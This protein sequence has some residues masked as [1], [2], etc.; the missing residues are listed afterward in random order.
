[1]E[2]EEQVVTRLVQQTITVT[3]AAPEIDAPEEPINLD[4][5]FVREGPP[6][7]DPQRTNDEDGID[8]IENIFVGLTRYNHAS[9]QIEPE[10]AKE[11]EVSNNGRTWTFHLR[12]DIFWIQP[13]ESVTNGKRAVKAVRQVVAGDLVF[14][15]QRA[16]RRDTRMPDAFILF[17]IEG[18]EQ[19]NQ[20]AT[21]TPA[22]L[23]NIGIQALNDQTLQIS[24]TKPASHFLT[25]TSMWFFRPMPP[26]LF[27]E[28]VEDWMAPELFMTSGPFFPLG[29]GLQKLQRNP[30]W[31]IERED[32]NVDIVNIYYLDNDDNALSLWEAKTLDVID[33]GTLD[34]SGFNS[35]T[36]S[37]LTVIPE[38]AL[39]YLAFNFN[40]GVFREPEVRR[41]FSA[42]I[43][44]EALVEEIYGINA[45]A[46]R[47]LIPPGVIAAPPID[48][49]GVGYSPDYARQ[50]MA[51]SGFSSCRLMP[52]ITFTVSSSDLS[53]LQAELIV[54]MWV[55]ELGC[56]EEQFI[57]EQVQFGTLLAN[58]R[59]EA[60]AARPDVWEL[61]WASY[62]P[63]AHNWSGDLL[64]CTESEN[65]ENRP[66][67]EVDELIRQA[68]LTTDLAE[69]LALYR[70]IENLFFGD[71]GIM[72]I[73]PLYVRGKV[74]LV[75]GWLT[76]AP[77]LFG[78][79]QYDS[80]LI[81]LS[82]KELEQSRQN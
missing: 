24:L 14:A 82:Q 11:W 21:A 19:V 48:Q 64:H 50:Q 15:I 34:P 35:R 26:E 38:Q 52:D 22:D 45:L 13:E 65:R 75:Q 78:G 37:H 81:D 8:L 74:L 12:D 17:L 80:Y 77:A 41:A 7:I 67:S 30:L 58:T 6:D 46:M 71:A 23:A 39:F 70:Q 53:L 69:R 9:N 20:Q 61:G 62:Y 59:Q 60:G 51:A 3:P 76:Y 49:V 47:H 5:S 72:P 18:C 43:D 54:G 33:V 66:C 4:I 40:S 73:A 28:D 63:D 36:A 68:T 1:V 44:R 42:A 10:L 29:E 55:E 2:G 27:T 79:E 32:G 25:I 16:C 57:L 56:T 31:P